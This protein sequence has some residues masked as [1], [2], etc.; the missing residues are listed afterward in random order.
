MINSGKIILGCSTLKAGGQI[1]SLLLQKGYNVDAICTS[2][3][4]L[5]RKCRMTKADLVILNYELSDINGAEVAR[6][7]SSE[8]VSKVIL[9][10]TSPQYNVISSWTDTLGIVC[11]LKPIKPSGFIATVASVFEAI[12]KSKKGHNEFGD[13]PQKNKIIIDKAKQHLMKNLGLD[14]P[15]AYRRIQKESMDSK[16][17]MVEVAKRILKE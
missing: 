11:L 3:N 15:E 6:I 9:L 14:E 16:L 10:C 13:R 12:N 4:M 1:K 7:L 17:P 8:A 5:I 2:G